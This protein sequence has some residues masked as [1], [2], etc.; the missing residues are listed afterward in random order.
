MLTR[1]PI[2]LTHV[3]EAL[4]HALEVAPSSDDWCNKCRKAVYEKGFTDRAFLRKCLGAFFRRRC[5]TSPPEVG[6][7]FLLCVSQTGSAPDR[8]TA[9]ELLAAAPWLTPEGQTIDLRRPL[10]VVLGPMEKGWRDWIQAVEFAELVSAATPMSYAEW[11]TQG[12]YQAKETLA[13]SSPAESLIPISAPKPIRRRRV[14][15]ISPILFGGTAA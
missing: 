5:V 8:F 6:A 11:E 1:Q 7:A 12:E 15:D 2:N 14:A 3:E 9:A 10:G 13:E 4:F